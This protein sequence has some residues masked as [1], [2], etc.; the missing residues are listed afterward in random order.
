VRR[1]L[2]QWSGGQLASSVRYCHVPELGDGY[3][4]VPPSWLPDRILS[5][6]ARSGL[7][8]RAAGAAVFAYPMP[9]E[10]ASYGGRYAD[11]K[12]RNESRRTCPP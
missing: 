7:V 3:S 11:A 5:A 1:W 9:L 10:R 12:D 2:Q 4:S 6:A 8:R